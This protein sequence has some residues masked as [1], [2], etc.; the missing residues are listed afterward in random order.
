MAALKRNKHL[1]PVLL[2]MAVIFI[3]SAMPAD[4]S[5]Q[6]SSILVELLRKWLHLES[7]HLTF[8]VRKS[9]HFLEYTVLGITLWNY[10]RSRRHHPAACMWKHLLYAWTAGVLYA[11]SDEVHQHFV[12]GRS[13]EIR[14][15]LIDAAGV[16]A[17][18]LCMKVIQR[19]KGGGGV[20]RDGSP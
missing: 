17:G 3:H 19:C 20:K 6:E 12:P 18:I 1:L 8:F 14:D 4:L 13:C 2:V 11:V 15:I 16:A 10:A 9:A 7:E 5:R